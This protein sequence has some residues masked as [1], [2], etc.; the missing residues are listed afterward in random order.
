V[1]QE[2]GQNEVQPR[3]SSGHSSLSPTLLASPSANKPTISIQ[4][5]IIGA[6]LRKINKGNEFLRLHAHT[7]L[8]TPDFTYCWTELYTSLSMLDKSPP[9][10]PIGSLSGCAQYLP[11]LRE[12]RFGNRGV[13]KFCIL[14]VPKPRLCSADRVSA[15]EFLP[16]CSVLTA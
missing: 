12:Y 5:D 7:E 9:H 6:S 1:R 3:G 2:D 10:A 11:V 14:R 16:A 15:L 13:C 4:N 8:L